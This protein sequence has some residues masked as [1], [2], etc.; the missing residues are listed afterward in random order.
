MRAN[1][2]E[3]KIALLECDI[4]ITKYNI[5]MVL[6]LIMPFMLSFASV[7]IA[8]SD[9]TTK[10]VFL[11]LSIFLFFILAGTV[12]F[13]SKRLITKYKAKKNLIDEKFQ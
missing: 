10:Y 8:A 9:Q 11:G 3:K 13:D 6:S 2:I 7:G 4:E 12:F 1:K 5:S